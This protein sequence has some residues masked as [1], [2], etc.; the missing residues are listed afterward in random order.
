MFWKRYSSCPSAWAAFGLHSASFPML[1]GGNDWQTSFHGYVRSS[2][3]LRG[4]KDVENRCSPLV[5]Y[6]ISGGSRSRAGG[7]GVSLLEIPYICFSPPK[8]P[9]EPAKDRG[10]SP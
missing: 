10:G 6:Y 9:Q 1:A 5:L 8:H 3:S 4:F 2:R 7:G